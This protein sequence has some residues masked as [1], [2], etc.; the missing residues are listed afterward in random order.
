MSETIMKPRGKFVLL[1]ITDVSKISED[2]KII[3][4]Q[5]SQLGKEYRVIAVGPKVE[6]LEVGDKV[7]VT[8]KIGTG[9]DFLPN[10]REL[11]IAD[12]GILIVRFVQPKENE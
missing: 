11:I 3:A 7:L 4:P 1:K 9:W 2:S 10:S 12:E 8:G 5:S 6:D